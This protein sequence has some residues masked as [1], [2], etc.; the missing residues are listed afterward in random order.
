MT[1]PA[2]LLTASLLG[3]L[4][5]VLAARCVALRGALAGAEE[6][7]RAAIEEALAHRMRVMANFVEYVPFALIQLAAI[8]LVVH[9]T[10]M[11]FAL[12]GT[13][14]IARLL[15][16]W[17]YSRSTGRSAGRYWGTLLT[18]LVIAAQSLIGLYAVLLG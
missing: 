3:L 12:G 6:D 7:G 4:L 13:L 2:T 17:G 9:K 8:E 18:W 10:M 1:I 5:L 11:A 16:A 15:H 14:V